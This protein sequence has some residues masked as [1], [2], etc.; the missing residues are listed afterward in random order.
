M[1]RT[2]AQR[3]AKYKRNKYKRDEVRLDMMVDYSAKARLERLAKYYGMTQ[4]EYL[5]DL[6]E[7]A[8][9]QVMKRLSDDEVKAYIF[10][11]EAPDNERVTG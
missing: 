8:D 11:G 5:A 10:K 7:K 1:T 3:Q 4:K 2:N 9:K 6:L